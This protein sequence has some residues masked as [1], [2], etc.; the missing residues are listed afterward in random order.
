[1]K[2]RVLKE[3]TDNN[4]QT[5]TRKLAAALEISQTSVINILHVEK[6]KPYKFKVNCIKRETS[7]SCQNIVWVRLSN[8]TYF[9]LFKI[10]QEL[11]E[12]NKVNRVRLATSLLGL[13]GVTV[14]DDAEANNLPELLK[15]IWF[16]GE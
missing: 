14:S 3:I 10:C 5:S 4:G 2:E 1:M 15:N 6:L 13:L 16:S 11:T 12:A 8:Q 7:T 9:I